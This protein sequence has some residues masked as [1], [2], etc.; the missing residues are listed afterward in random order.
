MNAENE[1]LK[2]IQFIRNLCQGKSEKELLEAEES[3][4]EYILVVKEICDRIDT[5]N[6]SSHFDEQ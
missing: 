1:K 4:R 6:I 5:S 3:F 2:P